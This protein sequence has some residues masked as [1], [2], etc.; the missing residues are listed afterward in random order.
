MA[1]TFSFFSKIL[2]EAGKIAETAFDAHRIAQT[3]TPSAK[4][5]ANAQAQERADACT[6]C[7][8]N[9]KIADAKEK[10]RAFTKRVG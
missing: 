2:G 7:A 10:A 3:Q 1:N 4:R 8:V 5:K 6:P 9:G